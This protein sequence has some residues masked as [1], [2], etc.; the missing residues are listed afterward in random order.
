MSIPRGTALYL[1][2]EAT[3]GRPLTVPFSR[4]WPLGA[5]EVELLLYGIDGPSCGAALL[6]RLKAAFPG[7]D[8]FVQT[9]AETGSH[10]NSVC[11]KGSG[12]DAKKVKSVITTL[13]SR[14]G[15]YTVA[16]GLPP[17]SATAKSTAD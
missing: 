12:V 17:A 14:R 16:K 6:E 4:C 1:S 15:K 10:P 2:G 13:D 9:A 11:V 3:P 5:T 8:S 7:A